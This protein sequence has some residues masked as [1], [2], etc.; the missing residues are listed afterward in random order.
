MPSRE[1]LGSSLARGT[2]TTKHCFAPATC[3]IISVKAFD[4]YASWRDNGPADSRGSETNVGRPCRAS[5]LAP[6]SLSATIRPVRCRPSDTLP[7]PSSPRAQ[8]VVQID[9]WSHRCNNSLVRPDAPV[10]EDATPRPVSNYTLRGDRA[11]RSSE[12]SDR[13]DT[14]LAAVRTVPL[15]PAEGSLGLMRRAREDPTRRIAHWCILP[16][17]GRKRERS[18]L[19]M[20]DF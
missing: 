14:P 20:S 8:R 3:N 15:R 6:T 7:L 18:C 2:T 1:R 10:N 12:R 4:L 9:G 16:H 11:Y 17:G 19:H 13:S 5:R